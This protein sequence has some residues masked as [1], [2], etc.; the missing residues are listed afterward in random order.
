VPQTSSTTRFR[1]SACR[2]DRASLSCRL[3]AVLRART[4]RSTRLSMPHA[5]RNVYASTTSPTATAAPR[6]VHNTACDKH[7]ALRAAFRHTYANTTHNVALPNGLTPPATRLCRRFSAALCHTP[8]FSR[9]CLPRASL[10]AEGWCDSLSSG[11]S[12][13]QHRVAATLLWP[14]ASRLF[15]PALN[16]CCY[17]RALHAVVALPRG[18][19]LRFAPRQ[20]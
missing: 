16:S 13:T 17:S 2:L 4:A 3:P 9:F 18:S 20:T 7:F 14:C 8:R 1:A 11:R 15:D 19:P 10:N 12:A 5:P 6:S